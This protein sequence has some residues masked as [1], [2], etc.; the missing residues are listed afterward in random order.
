[1]TRSIFQAACEAGEINII[2]W[3]VKF[4][5]DINA[6]GM[7]YIKQKRKKL[8]HPLD[9]HALLC[10]SDRGYQDIVEYL[11]EHGANVNAQGVCLRL[12][13]QERSSSIA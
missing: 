3:L 11:V 10:A 12:I 8:I 1:M 7:F 6:Q 9:G 5:A 13:R 2:R 4:G